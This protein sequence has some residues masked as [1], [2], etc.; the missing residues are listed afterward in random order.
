MDAMLITGRI[1]GSETIDKLMLF[2]NVATEIKRLFEEDNVELKLFLNEFEASLLIH[3]I[4]TTDV[5][6]IN[7]ETLLDGYKI[8]RKIFPSIIMLSVFL[9]HFYHR[10][11]FR[12][13]SLNPGA[14]VFPRCLRYL[15]ALTSS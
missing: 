11:Y 7:H 9:L 14:L 1:E 8:S 10:K 4:K 2:K 12:R 5:E 13:P 15:L 6:F 3:K